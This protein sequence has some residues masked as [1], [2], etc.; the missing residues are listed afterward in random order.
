[1]YGAFVFVF[2]LDDESKL[3]NYHTQTYITATREI[4]AS[5]DVVA[6]TW[7]FSASS[8]VGKYK[9]KSNDNNWLHDNSGNRADRCNADPADHAETHS[10]ILEEVVIESEE[11]EIPTAVENVETEAENAEIYDL[12]G[13][14]VKNISK[15]GIYIINGNKVLVK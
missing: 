12:T 1:M 5:I 7:T 13:C 6:N 15:A 14:K 3:L 2:Y 10:W 8:I 4:A 11:P 9:I